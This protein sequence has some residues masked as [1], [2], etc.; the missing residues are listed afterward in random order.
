MS[1]LPTGTVTFLFTDIEGSTRLW[2]T[3]PDAMHSALTRHDALLRFAAEQNHGCIVKTTGDGI[4]AVFATAPQALRAALDAQ[5]ALRAEPES[6][7]GPLRV[8]MGLHTGSAELRDGDYY[9]S[10]LNRAARLMAAGHG[11][12]VLLSGVT[13][14]LVRD[15]LPDGARLRDLGIHPLKD[16]GRPEQIFQLLHPALPADFPPLRSLQNPALLNNLPQQPTS[17]IGREMQVAEVKALLAKTRLLTLT[18]AGGAGKTRLSLQAAADLLDGD[19]D[20]VWLAEL[21]PLSDPALVPQAV[22]DVLGIKEQAGQPMARTVVDTLKT[23][24]LLLILDNC[25]HLVDACA[26]LAAG[27]LRSCPGVHILASSREPLHVAGE[28]T[29]RVPSLA[30]PDLSKPQTIAAL[31]EVE[32]VRL[33]AER[34]Q[35]VQPA[36]LLSDANARVVAQVCVRLDGIPLAIEL[37]ATRVRSLSVEEINARL[38]HRFRLLSGGGRTVLPRQQTLRALIDWSYDLLTDLEKTTLRRL[39]V[40]AGGW[41]LP[42]AEGVCS[43]G[44]I[45]ASDVLDLLTGL[46]DKSLVVYG[47]QAEGAGD[48][49]RLLET[50]RQYAH[51]RLEEN[52]EAEAVCSRASAWFLGFAEEAELH[53]K[54]PEQKAWLDRLDTEHDNLRASLSWFQQEAEGVES[55]LRLAGALWHFWWIRGHYSEGRLRSGRA[56][57]R[58]EET[59]PEGAEPEGTEPERVSEKRIAIA[60]AKALGGAAHLASEQGDSSAARVMYEESVTIQR[61]TG[62]YSTIGWALTGL[63]RM[64]LIE[65]DLARA[66]ALCEEG[67]AFRRQAE[68]LWGIA[69]SLICLGFLTISEGG[70]AGAEALFREA[71]TLQRQIGERIGGGWAVTGLAGVA[72]CQKNYAQAQTLYSE[73]LLTFRQQGDQRGVAFAL[74]ALAAVAVCQGDFPGAQAPFCESLLISRRLGDPRSIAENLEGLADVACRH[75]PGRAVRLAAAAFSVREN[76]GLRRPPA[77]AEKMDALMASAC[78]ALG[79]SAFSAAWAAGRAMNRDEAIEYALAAPE[80]AAGGT[81]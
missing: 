15:H 58:R 64:A 27:L 33:F 18:G 40:F 32:A 62:D 81:E 80:N 16:L 11:G 14:E 25:E 20:G 38:D 26:S 35:A 9:G 43:G 17:F 22:A 45:D 76:A 31:S 41:T 50:I 51:E 79:E 47:E 30:L 68:D 67:M 12:Q 60:A 66:R 37:A 21:A 70:L 75:Q 57:A 61:Q 71:L 34:A 78:E 2:E 53:A 28:Q 6:L 1:R 3:H 49:Y 5:C 36:F 13:Q 44:D 59:K 23:R 77:V 73:G 8:R 4:H 69:H 65:G 29:Y 7:T 74:K 46:V 24:R 42:A 48:R 39:S 55:G 72:L 10:V 56:L 63:G 19:G 54:G 52:K